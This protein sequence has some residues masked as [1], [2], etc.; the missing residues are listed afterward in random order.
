MPVTTAI[1]KDNIHG[2]QFHPEKSQNNGLRLFRNF[3]ITPKLMLKKRIVKKA[4]LVVKNGIVVQ[5]RMALIF[6]CQLASHQ[7]QWS[8]STTGV[9]MKLYCSIL[10]RLKK[11]APKFFNGAQWF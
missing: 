3:L 9:L 2:V 7:L 8:F 6:I 4:T 10:A 11:R 1:K 5:S